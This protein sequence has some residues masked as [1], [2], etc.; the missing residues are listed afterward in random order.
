[1]TL[2]TG[3]GG[4]TASMTTERDAQPL[5]PEPVAKEII[6]GATEGS[7]ALSLFRRLPD[8]TSRTFRMP[9]LDSLGAAS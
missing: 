2:I 5:I 8:M 1:M 6:T 4:G 3:P 7:A 9:V